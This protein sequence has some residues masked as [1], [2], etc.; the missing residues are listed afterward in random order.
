VI[1]STLLIHHF[2][3]SGFDPLASIFI[4]VLIL[5]STV[6]LLKTT[7]TSLLLVN[8]PEREYAL[9][10]VLGEIGITPGVSTLEGVRIWEGGGTLRV[11]VKKD[12]L[13][14]VRE[15]VGRVLGKEGVEGVVVD[16]VRA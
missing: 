14:I 15:R 5:A 4:T 12:D 10:D 16:V 2:N 3:W 6:P 1:I 13:G 8:T 9:R 11:K 7:A